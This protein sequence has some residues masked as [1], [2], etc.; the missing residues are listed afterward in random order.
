[1]DTL[2]FELVE[3]I[4]FIDL[5]TFNKMV[6]AVPRLG[7]RTS[8]KLY[9]DRVIKHFGLDIK[10]PK[11][12][13]KLQSIYDRPLC[14]FP[15]DKEWYHRGYI[16]RPPDV[17]GKHKYSRLNSQG[18]KTWTNRT[19]QYHRENGPA[20]IIP[21]RNIRRWYCVGYKYRPFPFPAEIRP[22]Y[23]IWYKKCE[24]GYHLLRLN[25]DKTLTVLILALGPM[26]GLIQSYPYIGYKIATATLFLAING[27]G[28]YRWIYGV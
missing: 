17:N 3:K 7:R 4:A 11:V 15:D 23:M 28:I 16:C 27:L 13:G 21:A 2:P 25:L 10:Y 18:T 20:V 6:R 12:F 14:I 26:M 5:K 8:D 9:Q 1:M 24:C 19:G 22:N